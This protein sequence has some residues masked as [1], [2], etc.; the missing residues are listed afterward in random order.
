MRL[1]NSI[2]GRQEDAWRSACVAPADHGTRVSE[3]VGGFVET[4]E[5]WPY[6]PIAAPGWALRQTRRRV[7]VRSDEVV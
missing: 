6:G 2:A 5:S 7:T 1:P 3:T 4:T